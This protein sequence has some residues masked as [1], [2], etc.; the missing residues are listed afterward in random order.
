MVKQKVYLLPENLAQLSDLSLV[1][2]LKLNESV[3]LAPLKSTIL[4]SLFTAGISIQYCHQFPN[5]F[6]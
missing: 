5:V 4:P 6:E 2:N 1:F 3:A